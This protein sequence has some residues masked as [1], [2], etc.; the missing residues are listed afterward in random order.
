M[1]GRFPSQCWLT[2]VAVLLISAAGH[3]ACER[4]A[5]EQA[6]VAALDSPTRRAAAYRDIVARC[7][8]FNTHYNAGRAYLAAGDA[9][10]AIAQF[11]AAR[12]AAADTKARVAAAMRLA[13]TYLQGDSLTEAM[14]ALNAARQDGGGP[15]PAWAVDVARRIDSHPARERVSAADMAAAM[16][17]SRS[18]GVR[19]RVDLRIG[20]DYDKDTLDG[21][22]RAQVEELAKLLAT[23]PEGSKLRLIGHSDA[24]GD[25]DYNQRLSERRAQSV[26]HA[27]VESNPAWTNRLLAEGRGKRELLYQGDGE[28]EHRLNRRV[29]IVQE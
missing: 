23:L 15:L 18:Y 17:S 9:A 7:P 2:G 25:A 19:P 1:T 20:F 21:Q 22:G 12:S 10:G 6:E 28:D 27:L 16:G 8:Q 13:E 4:V 14:A 24:R 11:K 29:E 5:D 3:A 26:R